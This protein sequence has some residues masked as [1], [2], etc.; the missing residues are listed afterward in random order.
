M[1]NDGTGDVL[2]F[3]DGYIVNQSG[4][5]P[6][7][8]VGD[9]L[10][11]VGLSGSFAQGD[12]IRVRDTK[13]L[14]KRDVTVPVTAVGLNPAEPTGTNGWYQSSVIVD[15]SATDD[16]SGVESTYYRINGGDWEAYSGPLELNA[17]GIHT[18]DYYSED[19]AG[20]R[21]ESKS[22]EVKI[23]GTGPSLQVSV[24][25][26]ILAVPNHK[27]M[28]ITAFLTYE[29]SASGVDSVVLESI[30]VNEENASPDDIQGT[31]YGTLDTVFSLRS[32]RN[33]FGDGRVYTITYLVTDKAGNQMRG[34]ATVTI[35]KGNSG[36]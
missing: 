30:T 8:Q 10:K 3:T 15:L 34:T 18:V 14:K 26:P 12:R 32:E 20:N 27:M 23:D 6:V 21:E 5:V 19:N 28:D 11:A 4:P 13:E 25:K 1:I 17:D 22:V 36:K 9:T 16:M 35:P 31:E 2:V 7:L 24:D 29:D 33:G